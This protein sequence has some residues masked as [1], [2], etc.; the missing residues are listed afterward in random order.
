V[1]FSRGGNICDNLGGG[2]SAATDDRRINEQTDRQTDRRT[3]PSPSAPCGGGLT[4]I[5]RLCC[6]LITDK[7]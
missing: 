3:S 1:R 5:W 4:N 6:R 2:R 7:T